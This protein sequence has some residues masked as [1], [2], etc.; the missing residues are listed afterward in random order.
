M[1]RVT[2]LIETVTFSWLFASCICLRINFTSVVLFY[3]F[4]EENEL[5]AI[6]NI[7]PAHED[8]FWIG[9]YN[10]V[11]ISSF[12]WSDQSDLTILHWSSKM[13]RKRPFDMLDCVFIESS[14]EEDV[15]VWQLY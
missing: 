4:F 6:L 1:R 14:N 5:F 7:F 13:L 8:G 15:R 3:L 12:K 9:L 10:S 11:N 2:N